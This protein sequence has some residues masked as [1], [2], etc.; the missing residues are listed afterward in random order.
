MHSLDASVH[1]GI[2]VFVATVVE[3]A[4]EVVAVVFVVDFVA[5]AE[6]ARVAAAAAI[7]V[8]VKRQAAVTF[9]VVAA[10][11]TRYHQ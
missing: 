4:V 2:V 8:S 3:F 10:Q 9:V 7:A 6:D 1:L 11:M 5:V